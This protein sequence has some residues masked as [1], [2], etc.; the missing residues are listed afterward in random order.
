MFRKQLIT[1]TIAA[2]LLIS[3]SQTVEVSS[4]TLPSTKGKL[5]AYF[6]NA[7]GGSNCTIRSAGV[8]IDSTIPEVTMGEAE[9]TIGEC[10]PALYMHTYL[11]PTDGY[12]C[13]L[14][15]QSIVS[16]SF[17]EVS[18]RHY[19]TNNCSW[20]TPSKKSCLF[21]DI[22][23]CGNIYGTFEVDGFGLHAR[24]HADSKC[25]TEPLMT[26]THSLG[27]CIPSLGGFYNINLTWT[28][29]ENPPNPP[30]KGNKASSASSHS[31]NT[32]GGFGV[33]AVSLSS[34]LILM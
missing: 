13:S 32:L 19:S 25:K 7:T 27:R 9:Y 30:H 11:E 15:Q 24:Y 26:Q 10:L 2:W 1:V 33:L 12:D 6:Y 34:T 31:V 21:T 20:V 16:N 4:S 22:Q 29:T 28:T 5:K 8:M 14:L 18:K 23:I 3:T 17:P